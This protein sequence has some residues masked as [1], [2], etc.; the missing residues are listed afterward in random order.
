MKK[1]VRVLK[2]QCKYT[3]CSKRANNDSC[4]NNL[5]PF[6][7]YNMWEFMEINMEINVDMWRVNTVYWSVKEN[8]FVDLGRWTHYL[9]CESE[10]IIWPGKVNISFDLWKLTHRLICEWTHWLIC[11]GEHITSIWSVKVN[12]LVDLWKWTYRLICEGLELLVVSCWYTSLRGLAKHI[13]V[14]II[15]AWGKSVNSCNEF[16]HVRHTFLKACMNSIHGT[17][18]AYILVMHTCI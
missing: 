14:Y 3:Y 4:V 10:H 7:I 8:T 9:I 17:Q 11:E 18:L 6:H 13:L 12:T 1:W 15:H 16:I 5:R 2:W